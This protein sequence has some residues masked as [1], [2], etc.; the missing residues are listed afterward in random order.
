MI[1]TTY[2]RLS[3]VERRYGAAPRMVCNFG[4]LGLPEMMYY[5][6]LP[7]RMRGYRIAGNAASRLPDWRGS[8]LLLPDPLRGLYDLVQVAEAASLVTTGR[9]YQYT[10]VSAR[11]GWATPDAPLNRPGWHADGF[12]TDDLNYVWWKGA[13]TRF[14]VQE[15]RDISSDH[16][17][18]IRQFE[19]QIDP[20]AV[21]TYPPGYLWQLTPYVVHATPVIPAPGEWREY[22]KV[23]L[24]DHRYNLAGNSHNYLFDYDWPIVGREEVRNDTFKAGRDYA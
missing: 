22:I 3:G 24:S 7:V 14:A 4:L 2:S 20:A 13:G 12:G 1:P 5:L 6:Y 16:K 18:S 15:F 8:P 23:S 9:V 17:E 21:R 11:R 19:E 10:Y